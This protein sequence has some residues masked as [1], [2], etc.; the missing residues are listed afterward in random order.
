MEFIPTPIIRVKN[1]SI[2]TY[3]TAT[4]RKRADA[5]EVE[6]DKLLKDSKTA[7][8]GEY[9]NQHVFEV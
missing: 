5:E 4:P 6:A 7:K 9:K 2:F 1:R 8:Q 3:E